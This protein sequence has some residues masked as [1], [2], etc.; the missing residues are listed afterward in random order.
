MSFSKGHRF[1]RCE[2]PKGVTPRLGVVQ[3]RTPLAV[4][5]F[6]APRA[7]QGDICSVAK[8]GKVS[9][10]NINRIT[11]VTASRQSLGFEQ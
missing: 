6:V 7:T 11:V 9:Y 3:V 10:I 4:R 8:L 2:R 5:P 1:G